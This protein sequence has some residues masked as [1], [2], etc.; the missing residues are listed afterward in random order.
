[1]STITGGVSKPQSPR[2]R[3]L[4]RIGAIALGTGITAVTLTAIL[5]AGAARSS[6]EAPVN[7]APS[8]GEASV[9]SSSGPIVVAV[10]LGQSG[11]DGA[12]A[13]APYE[14]FARSAQFSV[15]SVAATSA[16]VSMNG[17]LRVLPAY[18]FADAAAGTA[19]APDLIVVPAVND[20]AG[21]D[22][23]KLRDYVVDQ[24][25]SGAQILGICAGS[26]VL[27]ATGLL[28]GHRAT[29]HWSRID[30][31]KES[32]PQVTWLAGQR[33]VQDGGITT[34]AGVTSGIPA[35][36]RLVQQFAGDAEAER[37]GEE[38]AYPSWR[39]NASTSIPIQRF[40]PTD[41]G[42]GLNVVL[43]WLRPTVGVA[44]T[45]GVG[46]VDAVAP[47]EVGSYSAATS[48]I[49]IGARSNITTAHGLEILTTP[50]S[51]APSSLDRLLVTR[52]GDA[53]ERASLDRWA[54]GRGIPSSA[55]RTSLGHGG[56]DA[57]L[58]DL[59]SHGG[60][61]LADSTAKLIDYPARADDQEQMWVQ[62]RSAALLVL[63][64]TVALG[65]GLTPR[66]VRVRR[67]RHQAARASKPQALSLW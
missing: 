26:R 21:D 61:G 47:F 14:V 37:I 49:P 50:A 17:G 1:L 44:L 2:A 60:Q 40:G 20:P 27:A 25:H 54:R 39:L 23:A 10:A 43:P 64:L 52:S 46:E 34:S 3:V 58:A 66:W 56:F 9:S 22:E 5:V 63:S 4:R 18:T 38:M 48:V 11:T 29:S 6:A 19:P 41:L 33:Y 12:D 67:Q 55:L 45:E 28:D 59:A 15:Y 57:A 42:V 30:Q 51:A 24:F 32:N 35:A 7:A 13:L 16:P 36:L 53:R 65:A 31:L 62:P 8:R